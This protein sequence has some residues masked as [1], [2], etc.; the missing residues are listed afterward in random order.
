LLWSLKSLC[1]L[2]LL[3]GT[4]ALYSLAPS[5]AM[6]LRS[7]HSAQALR[8]EG[9]LCAL[10]VLLLLLT[11]Q[12]PLAEGK[13]SGQADAPCPGSASRGWGKGSPSTSESPVFL[14][15]LVLSRRWLW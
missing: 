8:S 15:Q 12:A 10:L 1:F 9:S 13:T 11:P 4:R 6:R 2:Q 14:P 3:K 7:C 5:F